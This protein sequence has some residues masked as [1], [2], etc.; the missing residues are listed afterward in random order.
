MPIAITRAHLLVATF[1]IAVL[2][3]AFWMWSDAGP[4]RSEAANEQAKTEMHLEIEGSFAGPV[5]CDSRTQ[6]TC[7]LAKGSSFS[8]H[9][10]PSAIPIGGYGGWQ[11]RIEYGSL[12][13]KPEPLAATG[14]A[15]TDDLRAQD[16]AVRR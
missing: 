7:K 15:V 10:I 4:Q 12:L 13:Y 1:A 2:A 6:T 8:V 16:R 5:Y 14:R 11:S 9:I 3:A